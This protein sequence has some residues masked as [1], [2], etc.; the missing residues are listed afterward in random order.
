MS[1]S[2]QVGLGLGLDNRTKHYFIFCTMQ[3]VMNNIILQEELN[4]S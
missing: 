2:G 3:L 1:E 4:K